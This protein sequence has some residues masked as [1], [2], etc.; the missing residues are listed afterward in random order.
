MY[1][2][3]SI[4]AFAFLSVIT[5][6]SKSH[7]SEGY[8]NLAIIHYEDSSGNNLFT[9][10][11]NGFV[12]DSVR[13]YI[14]QGD[15]KTLINTAKPGYV[16]TNPNGYSYWEGPPNEPYATG[17]SIET[18]FGIVNDSSSLLVHLRQGIDDTLTSLYD[19]SHHYM[20]YAWYN[21]VPE[22]TI[23]STTAEFTIV[24]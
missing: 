16:P 23:Q 7:T 15:V 3:L 12:V 4:L 10:G 17:L 22:L 24:K 6:C 2:R 21:G 9:G 18:D 14:L 8:S 19:N 13:I 5:S 1:M 11:Q 20:L